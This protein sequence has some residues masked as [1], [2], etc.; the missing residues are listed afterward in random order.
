MKN[1]LV[2][3]VDVDN[4]LLDNDRIKAE[5]KR[6]LIKVLGRRE[7]EHF[8]LHHDQF[9]KREK[10]VDYPNIIQ[11]YCEEKHKKTCRLLIA[12][13]FE[14]IQFKHVLFPE[15]ENVLKHLK[16]IGKVIIFSESDD[17]YQRTKITKSGLGAQVDEVLLFTHKLEHLDEMIKRY[18][19]NYLVFLD[20]KGEVLGKIKE[21]YPTAFT[22]EVCQGHYCTLDHK[23]HRKLDKKIYSIGELLDFTPDMFKKTTKR[24]IPKKAKKLRKLSPLALVKPPENPIISPREENGWEAWQ[25]FNPGV[26]LLEGNVYFLYRAIGE[27]GISRLGYAMSE[28]GFVIKERLPYSVY[29]HGLKHYSFN[30]FSYFSGGS[31]GGVED[32]RLVRVDEEDEIYMTYTACEEGLRVA[33][34]SISVDDFLQRKWRWKTPKLISAPNGV[35]KNWVIFPEKIHGQY[36]ILHSINPGIL[37]DY[38]DDLEFS[39]TAYI[40]SYHNGESDK[41]CW[42]TW[43]R[44]VGPVPIKTQYGWLIFYHAMDNDWSKYKVGAMLLDLN[45]PTKVLV[46]TK[47]PVLE[48]NEQYENNGFKSGVVYASGAVVKDHKLLVYY[49]AADSYVG[50]AYGD[51]DEFLKGLMNEKKPKLETKILKKKAYL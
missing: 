31:F 43:I 51:F 41:N 40:N 7:A 21:K 25:T 5:I 19:G 23:A 6:S 13:I 50:V 49:G 38:F 22:I 15:T 11:E 9:R 29:E 33:L 39:N 42:E 3:F 47:E 8:W 10:L 1:R 46:C 35:H 4:T 14:D 34:T 32:P 28:D 36:A 48:P 30:V 44:G 37:V 20:D 17:E 45:D 26:I 16:T 18:K 12:N 2:L 27:D 24:G